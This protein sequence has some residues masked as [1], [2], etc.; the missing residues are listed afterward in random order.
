VV[1]SVALHSAAFWGVGAAC[2]EADRARWDYFHAAP[3]PFGGPSA[4]DALRAARCLF[5][6]LAPASAGVAVFCARNR[7]RLRAALR[8]RGSF[9]RDLCAWCCCP[10]LALEQEAR[11]VAV[12]GHL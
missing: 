12:R 10:S 7:S 11:T 6:A 2:P 9:A 4:C 3:T 5:F 8:I 1:L